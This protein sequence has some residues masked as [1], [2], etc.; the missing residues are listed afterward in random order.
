MVADH[1]HQA[2]HAHACVT[3]NIGQSQNKFAFFKKIHLLQQRKQ[4]GLTVVGIR[5]RCHEDNLNLDCKCLVL[6]LLVIIMMA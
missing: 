5:D 3:L 4:C 6:Y 2:G 1:I